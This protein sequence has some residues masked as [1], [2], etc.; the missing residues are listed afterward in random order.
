MDEN[1]IKLTKNILI[2]TF[3]I[4]GLIVSIDLAYIYYQANFNQYSLPS[5][6]SVSEFIDCDGVAKT[7]ES[8]FFG[9]PLAYWGIFLYLFIIMLLLVDHLKKVPFLKFLEVFKNKY[10]YIA[11][12]GIIS[13]TISMILLCVSLFVINKICYMCA[14][15]YVIDLCIALIAVKGIEGNF[16][17]AIKQSWNDFLDALKPL[18][19]RIAFIV[20][21]IC[22][23]SFLGWTYVSAKFSPALKFK[24]EYGEFA[25]AKPTSYGTQGNV[26]GSKDKGAVVLEI[27]S[28]YMCPM[29]HTCN[30]MLNKVVSEFENL[31]IEAHSLPLD[32][33]CNKYLKQEFH[34]GSCTMAHY[35]EAARLQGK[36]WEVNN[37]FFEKKPET[38][39]EVINILK[40]SGYNLDIDK[41]QKDAN[42]PE[43][44]KLVQ[45]DIQYAVANKQVGTPSMKMDKDFEMGV[46]GYHQ[47]KKWIIEHGGKPKYKLF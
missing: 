19:Y 16:I 47:L 46:Q 15:T 4:L 6:C 8:Q 27:Y 41:L 14:I 12:L 21:M 26:L 10:H 29:C 30:N 38:E 33:S 20:V 11:S 32:T 28:D 17:G 42:S 22:A 45:D 36:F 18:P 13:F 3:V 40:D 9:I 43:I 35:A 34:H 24:R 37:L 7:T 2:S 25:K 1:K 39:E 5:F 23:C 31:R 44:Q